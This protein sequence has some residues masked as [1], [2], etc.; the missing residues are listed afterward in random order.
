MQEIEIERKSLLTKEEFLLL[1]KELPFPKSAVKQVNYYFETEDFALKERRAALRIRKIDQTYIL[2]LKEPHELG[3]LE[4][5]DELTYE[6]FLQWKNGGNKS[7]EHVKE[8]LRHLNVQSDRIQYL[9]SLTTERK[10]YLDEQITYMLDKSY[11]LNEVDYEIEI[12]APSN[13]L[14]DEAMSQLLCRYNIAPKTAFPKVKRF[15][16]ALKQHRK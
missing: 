8:R 4:T 10:T 7:G 11:Y 13:E 15:F 9:G 12:E 2:T 3:I 5:H 1:D 14:A 16:L 6:Q